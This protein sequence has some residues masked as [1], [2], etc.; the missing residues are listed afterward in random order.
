VIISSNDGVMKTL[1][2]GGHRGHGV[3]SLSVQELTSVSSA[4]S[5]VESSSRV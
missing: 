1:H 5:V 4:S 3:S 2:H